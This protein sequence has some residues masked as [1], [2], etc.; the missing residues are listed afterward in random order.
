[1]CVGLK[2]PDTSLFSLTIFYFNIQSKKNKGILLFLEIIQIYIE[3][4]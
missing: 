1:M 2:F 3:G 4:S